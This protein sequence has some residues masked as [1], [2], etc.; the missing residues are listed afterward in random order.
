MGDAANILFKTGPRR[1]ASVGIGEGAQEAFAGYLQDLTEKGLYNPNLEVG[2]SAMADFG[3]G[4]SAGA[5]FQGGLELIVPGL[6]N[7]RA[8]QQQEEERQGA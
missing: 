5:I 2:E 7:R 1:V 3:Y 4:A 8:I 6:R